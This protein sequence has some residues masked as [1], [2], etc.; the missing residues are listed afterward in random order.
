MGVLRRIVL[1][2]LLAAAG[3]ACVSVAPPPD[4]H[5][6]YQPGQ[7]LIVMVYQA[8]GPWIVSDT[9]SKLESAAQITPLGFAV[10]SLQNNHTLAVSKAIEQYLPRPRYD[11]EFQKALLA[12]LALHLSSAPLQTGLEAGITPEQMQRWNRAHDQLDWR[13][14]YFAP[15]PDGPP[16]RN[17]SRD[18]GFDDAL[19]LDANLAFGTTATDAGQLQPDLAVAWRVYRGLNGRKVWEGS[20]ELIDTTSSSTL[21]DIQT[22][23]SDLPARLE[24]LAPKLGQSVGHEFARAFGL[25]PSTS[26]AAGARPGLLP[27]APA[28]PLNPGLLPLDYLLRLSSPTADGAPLPPPPTP[29]AIPVPTLSTTT[30]VSPAAAPPSVALSTAAA[31]SAPVPPPV[32]PPSPPPTAVSPSSGPDK[33]P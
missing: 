7:R 31:P 4:P 28:A 14:I 24:T 13:Q 27:A 30:S 17:Y 10:A 19:I 6:V 5:G 21:V 15:D 33:S 9:D 22:N 8:P 16:P 11:E 12:E 25:L 29:N 18:Y 1:P 23:P 20:D 26:P 32:A 3:S 2:L